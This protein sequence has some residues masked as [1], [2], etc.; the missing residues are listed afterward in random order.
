MSHLFYFYSSFNGTMLGVLLDEAKKLIE[1]KGAHVY[2]VVCEGFL[3]LCLSNPTGKRAVCA[4]CT[5]HSLATIEHTLGTEACTIIHLRDY[6]NRNLSDRKFEYND[7]QG[8]KN[9]EYKGVQIGYASLS[10]YI[11][12]TRNQSPKINDLARTYFDVLLN[13]AVR[14]TDAFENILQ[15]IRP[16]VV[17]TYNGRFNEFRPIYETAIQ[18]LVDI[19]LYEVVK[20]KDPRFYKVAFKNMMPHN[21][22]KNLWRVEECWNNPKYFPGENVSL[23]NQFFTRR[24]MGEIAGDKVY[25]GMM[26][27]GKLPA[28][29]D[30]SKR[31]VVI[32]NSSEDEFVAIG[33]EYTSLSMFNSQ[34]D[35]IVEILKRFRYSQDLQFY[36]RIH[37]NLSKVKYKYHLDLYKLGEE[38]VNVTVIPPSSDV[39]SY[40]LLEACEKVIVFG[41]TLGLEA[42]Y[43]KKPAILLSCAFYYYADVCYVPKS[44]DELFDLITEYLEP[45]ENVNTL[46]YGLYYMDKSAVIIDGDSQFRYIDFNAFRIDVLGKR[47]HGFGYMKLF[48]SKKFAALS[49]GFRR[50]MAD[51]LS[52][53]R[54]AIPTEDV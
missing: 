39:N 43:W 14:L 34:M 1:D 5:K 45:I 13:Q 6:Y 17:H 20:L 33:D 41:S 16:D 46:K 2:F 37:P 11:Y 52:V 4:T 19:S 38:F 23:A 22:Q 42:S 32:F 18:N 53:S 28:N 9:I 7:V 29:W 49:L 54:F 36:V 44:K 15:H 3:D 50:F 27:K 25:V 21:V 31:N 47:L 51:K 40:D 48:G 35:G 26:T 10:S 8:L 12:L 24:R 30:A